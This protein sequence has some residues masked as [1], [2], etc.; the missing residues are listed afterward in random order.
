MTQ[1]LLRCRSARVARGFAGALA[2]L[3]LS[4]ASS[5][6]SAQAN[7]ASA[8]GPNALQ[9]LKAMSDYVTSQKTLSVDIEIEIDVSTPE[10]QKLQFSA[11]ESAVFARPDRIHVV[12]K[13][14]NIDLDLRFDGKTI[15]LIDAASSTYGQIA[16]SGTIET[17]LDRLNKDYT[18]EI[19]GLDPR[20]ANSYDRLSE[21]VIN[22]KRIGTDVIDGIECQHLAF[23]NN[24]TDWQLWVRTGDHPLPCKYIIV[25]KTVVGA[26]EYRI[27]Y[28]SW[29]ISPADPKA[30]TFMPNKAMRSVAFEAASAQAGLLATTSGSPASH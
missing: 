19:P 8:E 6:A 25:S 9:V 24:A 15:T 29:N 14:G 11:A 17:M 26:P 13:G 18:V 7:A 16:Q 23:R 3:S 10:I 27:R 30:F 21:G 20:L 28:R 4:L 12:R 2:A 5:A 1:I 22:A